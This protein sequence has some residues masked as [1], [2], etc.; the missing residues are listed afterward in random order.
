[1]PGAPRPRASRPRCRAAQ[2]SPSATTTQTAAASSRECVIERS[3][4]PAPSRSAQ[5]ADA[6]RAAHA[7]F[8]RPAISI[9]R[10]AN[11]RATPKPSALPTASLPAKRAGVVLRRVRPRVAVRALGLGEAALAER[12]VALERAPDPLDLDQVD[13]DR[14]RAARSSHSGSSAIESTTPSGVDARAARARPAGTCP[15]ARAPSACRTLCAPAMSASRSSP[16]I[17][18]SSGVG[19]ERLERS[20]EVRPGS[21]CRAPSPRRRPRTRARRRTRPASSSGPRDGLPPAVLVQA[22]ELGARL[23]LG[24]RAREVHVAEDAV[25][26]RRTRRR[27]RWSTASAPSPTSSMPSRSSTIAGI[28]SAST[29]WP[30]SARAAARG[31]RLQLVVVELDP[32]RAERLRE[33]RARDASCCW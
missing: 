18:V 23:E 12:R 3:I 20:L 16:T 7:G 1:M 5:A 22:V 31:G 19:V 33:R 14:S 27:R 15:S 4:G 8:G 17:Q 26:S 21:A 2:A 9:S 28:V 29:R 10:Q 30:A 11:A 32:E 13:A 24:E 6:A 25:R